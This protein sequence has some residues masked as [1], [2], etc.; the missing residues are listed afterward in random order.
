LQGFGL[1]FVFTPLSVVTFSTLP[2]H[3]LTQGTAMFSLMRNIGGSVGVSIVEALLVQNTQIIHSHMIERLHPDNP[4][5]QLPEFT[6][7]FSF[8]TPS[9]VAALNAEVTRQASM[10]A[11]I[12]NFYLMVLIILAALPLLLLLRRPGRI[13]GGTTAHA[14][15]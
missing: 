1:G 11:Y 3:Y 4:L 15:D 12:D 6:Q 13:G 7:H 9:G 14:M 5:T 10:I 8:T 2:R